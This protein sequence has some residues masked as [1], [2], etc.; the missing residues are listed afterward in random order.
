MMQ[1][2]P[3][4]SVIITNRLTTR[5]PCAEHGETAAPVCLAKGVDAG[6]TDRE[7]A[8]EHDIPIVEDPPWRARSTPARKSTN[9]SPGNILKRSPR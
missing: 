1:N 5:W 9:L 8:A 7:V 4:A 2:V 3:Q 6:A